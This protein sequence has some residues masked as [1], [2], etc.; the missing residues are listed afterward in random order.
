[1]EL[2]AIPV[3]LLVVAIIAFVEFKP[4]VKKALATV[5]VEELHRRAEKED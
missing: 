3:I 1:M 4:E 2:I 5:Q